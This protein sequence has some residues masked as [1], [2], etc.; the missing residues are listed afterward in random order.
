MRHLHS[1]QF[2]GLFTP[3]FLPLA[4]QKSGFENRVLSPENCLKALLRGKRALPQEQFFS[5]LI[6]QNYVKSSR[7]H[8][9]VSS[10]CVSA[11]PD[12]AR[13]CVTPR[14]PQGPGTAPGARQHLP[15]LRW[16]WR[17]A[18]FGGPEPAVSQLFALSCR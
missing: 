1:D 15:A 6:F 4:R 18:R 10:R 16:P 8:R 12:P 17:K 14:A 5:Y 9:R 3:G 13:S 7:S 2:T 11:G